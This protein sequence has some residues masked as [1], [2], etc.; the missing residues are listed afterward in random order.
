MRLMARELHVVSMKRT[1]HHAIMLWIAGHFEVPV[2]H[3]N[4][5]DGGSDPIVNRGGD[6]LLNQLLAVHPSQLKHATDSGDESP[7]ILFSYEDKDLQNLRIST[8][9]GAGGADGGDPTGVQKL[10]CIRDP[11]NMLASRFAL[12]PDQV[13]ASHRQIL[14]RWCAY[15]QEYLG[16]THHLPEHIPVAFNSW[17]SSVGYRQALSRRLGLAFTDRGFRVIP[18]AMIGGSSFDRLEPPVPI[19]NNLPVLSRWQAFAGCDEYWSFLAAS[20]RVHELSTAVFGELP[21]IRQM[22]S[23]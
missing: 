16:Q 17:F 2:R 11:Y 19:P 14:D 18:P 22:L 15:A 20:P 21:G 3:F 6:L 5:V 12:W 1:G 23:T 7:C 13:R 9:Q 4:D 8:A 10:L